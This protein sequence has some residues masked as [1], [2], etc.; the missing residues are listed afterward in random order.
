[1]ALIDGLI[2]HW[3]LD[4]AAGNSRVD[5]LGTFTLPEYSGQVAQVA[6]KLNYA[7][8]STGASS[9]YL[10]LN[11]PSSAIHPSTAYTIA[12]WV[13]RNNDFGTSEECALFWEMGSYSLALSTLWS[14]TF[15]KYLH[16]LIHYD[17]T[18]TSYDVNA[19]SA[20]QTWEFLVARWDGSKLD[21]S[22]NNG[23]PAET[24][25]VSSIVSWATAAITSLRVGWRNTLEADVYIDS[26]SV[27][28]RALS[29]AEVTQLYNGG[30][31]LEY[32]FTIDDLIGS[33][34]PMPTFFRDY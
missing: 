3:K 9:Y 1:M 21:L 22:V 20:L 12:A 23:T 29:D 34:R 33:H 32:P 31:G 26:L 30:D 24:P 28:H 4:E 10:R 17:S 19:D 5:E 27:W 18:P 14:D 13:Y 7:V 2:A 25:S 16:R 6:G 8:R 15:S 11:S